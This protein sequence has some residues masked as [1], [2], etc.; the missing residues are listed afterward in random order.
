MV[1]SS[2]RSTTRCRLACES[3]EE[4]TV[5][6]FNLTIDG[7]VAN[8][9]NMSSSFAN[10]A[11]TFTTTATGATL[12]VGDIENALALGNV[13]IST[14]ATGSENGNIDWIWTSPAD[15]LDYFGAERRSLTIQPDATST[16]GD[17]HTDN[18]SFNASDNLDLVVD[19]S[20]S[21]AN[22]A[23]SLLDDTELNN[24]ASVT[25]NAGMS[26]VQLE[27]SS[28]ASMTNSGDIRIT[29]STFYNLTAGFAIISDNGNIT[30]D[31]AIGVDGSVDLD[32]QFGNVTVTGAIDSPTAQDLS[33]EGNVS[34]VAGAIGLMDPLGNLTIA[35]GSLSFGSAINASG[36]FVGDGN[37]DQIATLTGAGTISA[38][39]DVQLDGAM[40]PSGPGGTGVMNIT[41]SL[42]FDGG[43]YFVKLG[44]TPDIIHVTGVNGNVTINAGSTLGG[45]FN[46]GMLTGPG[47]F[48]I[49]DFTGTLSG[50][51]DN[52]AVNQ[53]LVLG[54]DAVRV[55]HYGPAALGVTI[56]EVPANQAN[57]ASGSDAD[58][59]A[60][61]VKL[62]G[63][64]QLV[65]F[66]DSNGNYVVV[67]RNTDMK[68]KLS[69]T[70]TANASDD[71]VTINQVI[72]NGDLGAFTAPGVELGFS[73]SD[74]FEVTP[75][76]TTH[77]TVGTLSCY[78][79]GAPVAIA[80]TLSSFTVAQDCLG[81]VSAKAIGKVKIGRTLGGFA[82]W[83]TTFGIT[84][85][86]AA[87]ITDASIQ[88][89]YIG[90]LSVPGDKKQHL[91]GNVDD[92][93]VRTPGNDGTA[94][95]NGIGSMSIKGTVSD[96]TFN[97]LDGNVGA[98]TV[99]R[100][101]DSNIYL[102]FTPGV[103]FDTDGSYND[104]KHW[105][106]GTFTTTATT[107]G[108]QTN[109]LNWAF[110]GSQ[111]VADTIGTVRLSGLKTDNG[112]PAFGIRFRTA[113]GSVQAKT[114]DNGFI[115]PNRNLVPSNT[116]LAVDFFFEQL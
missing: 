54:S 95:L 17:F 80:D 84:S 83:L 71:L 93:T 20:H 70:T 57:A 44:A 68:S 1:E 28:S 79:L 41:G 102:D 59:T 65:T 69:I 3:L 62:A 51:F 16:V 108:D 55:T 30:I 63:N 38:D 46:I 45:N 111:I 94:K 78:S 32:A 26:I 66:T 107:I 106:L 12:A 48:K 87:E 100:F 50:A 109:P 52:A 96:S 101:I 67:A 72:V 23:I 35:A 53:S 2:R 8:S 104:L 31:G 113:A 5:P 43:A 22:G 91:A 19:T 34:S 76:Q 97:V 13:V 7:N 81:D 116:H 103:N 99:G 49:I 60:F 92:L 73:N 110:A 105:K 33:I 29:A 14:G 64:G 98:V 25:L 88:A 9:V 27:S 86:T 82:D 11:T 40:F 21:V 75:T 36:V 114:S 39:V 56:S 24:L 10:G 89:D 90:T 18:V 77:G 4:R 15:D 47:D 42:T 61:K 58:G 74:A 112:G 85:L 37:L 6:A 115:V